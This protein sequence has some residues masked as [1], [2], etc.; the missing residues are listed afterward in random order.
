MSMDTVVSTWMNG[1]DVSWASVED[2]KYV[3]QAREDY[4]QRS[5]R[6]FFPGGRTNV[7][8]S[9]QIP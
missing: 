5:W 1:I 4:R 7:T 6:L 8:S 3:A 2:A 9:K